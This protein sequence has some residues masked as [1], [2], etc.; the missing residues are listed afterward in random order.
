MTNN[1][2]F[3]DTEIHGFKLMNGNFTLCERPYRV[4]GFNSIGKEDVIQIREVSLSNE[5]ITC[6]DCKQMLRKE[7]NVFAS[8]QRKAK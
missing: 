4:I 5:D 6:G 7:L 3:E 8:T 1:K 2:N